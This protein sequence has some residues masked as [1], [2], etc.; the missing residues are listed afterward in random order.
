MKDRWGTWDWDTT[1]SIEAVVGPPPGC[2]VCD[3]PGPRKCPV[4]GL[5]LCA[6]CRGGEE[7]REYCAAVAAEGE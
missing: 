7:H 6:G 3:R 5:L 2:E 1:E 4:C